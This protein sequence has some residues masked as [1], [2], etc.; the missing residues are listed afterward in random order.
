MKSARIAHVNISHQP[1]ETDSLLGPCGVLPVAARWGPA[2]TAGRERCTT[3]LVGAAFR[4]A[5]VSPASALVPRDLVFLDGAGD[6]WD[7]TKKKDRS[8]SSGQRKPLW[9]FFGLI[10][11]AAR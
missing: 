9:P 10:E 4:P 1:F 2:G 6:G 7:L 5:N 8:K 11:E 3:C